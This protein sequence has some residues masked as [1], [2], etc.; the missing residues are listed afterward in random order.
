MRKVISLDKSDAVLTLSAMLA[1][2]GYF[3]VLAKGLTT[4]YRDGALHLD[5]SLDHI[6]NQVF[7]PLALLVIV[8]QNG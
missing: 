8:K 6:V 4:T 7:G 2:L 1:N 5:G 3:N